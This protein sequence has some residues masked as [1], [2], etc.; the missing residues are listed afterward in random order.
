MKGVLISF[1]EKTDQYPPHGN[2][3]KYKE[4]DHGNCGGCSPSLDTLINLLHTHFGEQ[5]RDLS[6][7][8]IRKVVVAPLTPGPGDPTP[9]YALPAARYAALPLPSTHQTH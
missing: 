6:R 7:D 4:S 3:R 8:S 2:E 5:R 1:F 9:P